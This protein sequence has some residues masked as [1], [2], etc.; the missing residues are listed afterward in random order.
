MASETA[1]LSRYLITYRTTAL[2]GALCVAGYLA[3]SIANPLVLRRAVDALRQ[4]GD[5]Q[6]FAGWLALFGVLAIAVFGLSIGMRR[7]LLGVANR[8]EHD[9][10]RDVFAHLTTLDV[11]Y[12]QQERTGDLMTKMGS[13]LA[14]VREMIGQGLLQ[15][16]RMALGFPLAFGVMFASNWRLA[17]VVAALLP[18]ISVLFFV[19]IRLV[20]RYYDRSQEQ[21]SAISNFAQET[22]AGIR[23]IKAYAV[24]ARRQHQFEDLNREYVRRNMALTRAETPVWPFMMF[25]YWLGAVLLLLAAGRQILDGTVTL[26]MYVQFQ[27]HLLFLQWPILALGWT[28]NLIQRGRT[29][30][31]RIRTILDARP[32][33]CDPGPDSAPAPERFDIEF[34]RVTFRTDHRDILREI[35]LFIPQGQC[36]GITGPTGSGKTTLVAL[37]ARL[38]DPTEGHVRIGGTDVSRMRLAD[39]RRLIAVA[40]QEPFLFSDTLANNLALGLDPV[41]DAM[42]AYEAEILRVARLTRLAEEVEQFPNRY[43]TLLGERGITLSGGQRQR[44]ALA[45]ALARNPRILILDDIFSAVD[46]QTE[47][48]ILEALLP[49]LRE[50]TTILVSHRISTLRRADRIVVIENGR[51]TQDGR[52]EELLARAGYYRELEEVQ[53]LASQLEVAEP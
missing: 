47:A 3:G 18:V 31:K 13:D 27:Q 6:P 12:F 48:A 4:G 39:L 1:K 20:R 42:E 40:P 35:S 45:R 26:G 8:V 32:R 25:L 9:I 11:A 15:G 37:I 50:R 36:V 41:D 44:A 21:F 2:V 5:M 28:V 22:F 52:H 30:W 49:L 17:L 38:T 34:D 51:I 23:T 33:V 10:R 43:R 14:A 46:T 53:R 7:I 29:S 16:S 24:E 19:L